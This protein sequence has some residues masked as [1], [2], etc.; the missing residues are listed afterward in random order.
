MDS[1]VVIVVLATALG[2]VAVYA[3]VGRVLPGRRRKSDVDRSP[4]AL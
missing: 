1:L 2:S 3:V 4:P